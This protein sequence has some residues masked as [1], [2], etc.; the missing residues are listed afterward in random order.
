MLAKVREL[1]LPALERAGRSRP[2]S[3][4]IRVFPSRG[5]TRSGWRDNIVGNSASRI[6][7]RWRCRFRWPVVTPACRWL[8][9][10]ICRKNGRPTGRGGAR[11]VC[12]SKLGLRPRRRLRLSNCAGRVPPGCRAAWFCS[13]PAMATTARCAPPSRRWDLSYVASIL[14][15]TTVWAPGTVPLPPK[16]W[17]GRGRPTTR[18]RRDARHQPVSVKDLAV[19]LSKRA[20]RTIEWREGTAEPL[21]SRFARV[22]RA[23]R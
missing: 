18:L 13:T 16:R 4:T 11:R 14:S 6:I 15:T 7:A 5:G 8:I 20:W 23:S 21:V 1:V 3:S 17:S 12:R 19:G 22:G 10:F 9:G 2:G